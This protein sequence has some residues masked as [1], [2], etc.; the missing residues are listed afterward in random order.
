MIP[1]KDGLLV[2]MHTTTC[3]TNNSMYLLFDL[4]TTGLPRR[5]SK[6]YSASY[7]DSTAYDS[8]R[9]VSISWMIIGSRP[10][11]KPL[12]H[13]YFIVR[14]DDFDIPEE[15]VRFHGITPEHAR[16]CGHS[17]DTILPIFE[18]DLIQCNVLVSHNAEFDVQVLKAELHRRGEHGEEH[19]KYAELLNCIHSKRVF[20]TMLE[21]QK[22]MGASKYPRLEFLFKYFYPE[23]T[24]SEAHNAYYDTLHCYLCFKKLK[25][26]KHER[27]G[28][29]KQQDSSI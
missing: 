24:L 17:F 11:Y 18:R 13:Q 26:L 20:C 14:P 25:A 1:L 9:I 7:K 3:E 23:E 19:G 21:G 4:E 16:V 6:S 29:Q 28:Q 5:G 15:S 27:Q 12:G 8:C 2:I 10:D 22:A